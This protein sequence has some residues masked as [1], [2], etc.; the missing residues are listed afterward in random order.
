MQEGFR[1]PPK[2]VIDMID[3][4][5][6]G[7]RFNRE[8]LD[9]C[10]R[11]NNLVAITSFEDREQFVRD[12]FHRVMA[13]YFGRDGI[14]YDDEYCDESLTYLRMNTPRLDMKYYTPFDPRVEV[15]VAD[16]AEFKAN[17]ENIISKGQDPIPFIAANRNAY[18]RPK[19][20]HQE[21]VETFADYWRSKGEF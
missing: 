19:R 13:I 3:F 5:R 18:T 1:H 17:V 9:L 21:T 14:M 4:V 10:S 6:N 11:N 2:Y 15:R 12:G 20:N 7:G 8:R 16:F